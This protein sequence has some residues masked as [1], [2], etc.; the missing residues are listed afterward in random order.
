MAVKE[1][2]LTIPQASR[3]CGMS[4]GT[5]W[6]Y[7]KKGDIPAS[8]TPGGQYRI[9]KKDFTAFMQ[10]NNMYGPDLSEPKSQRIL[11]VDDEPEILKMLTR[12]LSE[13]SYCLETA[14]DGF[15]AGMKIMTFKP[16]L[17]ILDLIMPGMDGFEVCRQ[18]K[19]NPDTAHIKV[20][21]VTGY[22]SEEN[23]QK[24]LS[25]GADAYLAKPL[26]KEELMQTI[27]TLLHTNTPN[28]HEAEA[29]G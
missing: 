19:A 24:I 25:E 12:I 22:D 23:R 14:K 21:A 7:V 28:T 17:V 13:E 1:T 29:I 15:D 11:I 9:R 2:L 4:R 5:I 27:Q 16:G 8:M 10:H 6:K 26:F 3:L 18:I 20:L